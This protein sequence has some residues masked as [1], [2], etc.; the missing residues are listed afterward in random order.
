MSKEATVLEE[1]L[2][3]AMD[4]GLALRDRGAGTEYDKGAL[5]AY[6]TLLNWGKTQ[7]ELLGVEFSDRELQAF[8]PYELLGKR[9][10]A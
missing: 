2:R 3:R 1:V 6:L 5:M 10:A 7:A 8:D 9:K 4:E